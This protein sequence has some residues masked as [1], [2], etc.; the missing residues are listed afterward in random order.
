MFIP[1]LII[2]SF[3]IT[4]ASNAGPGNSGG[5]HGQGQSHGQG[6]Q[7][8]GDFGGGGDLPPGLQ[9]RGKPYG[10]EKQ[11]KTPSGWSKG[12]KKGW[13]KRHGGKH[14]GDQHGKDKSRNELDKEDNH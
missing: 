10:L 11:N 7:N 2:L 5:G 12:K 4:T 13:H 9:K 1:C 3:F 8:A 6:H 14:H